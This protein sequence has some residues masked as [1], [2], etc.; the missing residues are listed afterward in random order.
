M[1]INLLC[2]LVSRKICIPICFLRKANANRAK[3]GKAHY[4]LIFKEFHTE[5]PIIFIDGRRKENG[6]MLSY[7]DSSFR[8]Y[9]PGIDFKFK[10]HRKYPLLRAQKSCVTHRQKR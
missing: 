2:R 9:V 7:S 5:K 8:G 1:F 3:F 6:G 10:L 4:S